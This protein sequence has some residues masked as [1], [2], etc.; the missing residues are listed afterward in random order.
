ME[1]GN[2]VFTIGYPNPVMQGLEP[3]YTDGRISSRAGMMDDEAFYQISVPV[4]PGNSG[5]PLIDMESGWAVGVITLR[6][7][8]TADGRTADNVSYALKGAVLH[9]FLSGTPEAAQ[10]MK[11]APAEKPGDGT[12]IITRAKGASATVLVPN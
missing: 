4:Q 2:T 7:D 9:K 1:L 5:G 10:S 11:S 6:L 3:K 12:A 8:R